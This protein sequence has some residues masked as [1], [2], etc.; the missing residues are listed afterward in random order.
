MS[1]PIEKYD[2]LK[3]VLAKL[4]K[5]DCVTGNGSG[6][7]NNVLQILCYHQTTHHERKSV[8]RLVHYGRNC[9]NT[10]RIRYIFLLR[11]LSFN[12]LCIF[13]TSKDE[14]LNIFASVARCSQINF[15]HTFFLHARAFYKGREMI[16][17]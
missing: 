5:C 7:K 8:Q 14:C 1:R 6:N 11:V 16:E 9:E 12:H 10:K 15:P 3:S 13:V 17:L 2:I 4:K